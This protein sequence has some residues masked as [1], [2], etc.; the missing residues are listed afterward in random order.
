MEKVGI[1]QAEASPAVKCEFAF[2]SAAVL[3]QCLPG[4]SIA[5]TNIWCRNLSQFPYFTR[6]SLKVQP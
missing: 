3:V 6:N 5:N 2:V 4:K 1:L